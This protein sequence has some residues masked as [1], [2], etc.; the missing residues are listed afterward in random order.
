MDE[1][2]S[3]VLAILRHRGIA[4]LVDAGNDAA[5]R[6]VCSARCRQ[7]NLRRKVGLPCRS[8]AAKVVVAIAGGKP[9]DVSHVEGNKTRRSNHTPFF[10]VI[11]CSS[12]AVR[13]GLG[14]LVTA[15]PRRGSDLPGEVF[16]CYPLA[17]WIVR[18]R[19]SGDSVPNTVDVRICFCSRISPRQYRS[20]PPSRPS[21]PPP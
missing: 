9:R 5:K 8:L 12:G 11:P 18:H 13:L 1:H 7:T 15:V 6:V 10:V 3:P 20:T 2:S 17:L 16:G 21:S 4:K 14:N 19:V